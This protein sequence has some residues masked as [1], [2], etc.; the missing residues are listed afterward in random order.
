MNIEEIGQR[1]TRWPEDHGP[2]IKS[3]DFCGDRIITAPLDQEAV[4]DEYRLAFIRE[5]LG[6][7]VSERAA[8]C[9]LSWLKH[10][11]DGARIVW[12]GMNRVM[13]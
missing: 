8:S 10:F 1:A 2:Q 4:L 11:E 13:I 9:V 12:A 7:N 3:K 5:V 6:P